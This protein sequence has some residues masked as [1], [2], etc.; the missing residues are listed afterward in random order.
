MSKQL[1]SIM[2]EKA[3]LWFDSAKEKLEEE[4]QQ[5]IQTIKNKP[6]KTMDEF[7]ENLF[8][9]ESDSKFKFC[10]DS[11]ADDFMLI[12]DRLSLLERKTQEK[13]D[14]LFTDFYGVIDSHGTTPFC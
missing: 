5:K 8:D 9:S 6:M 10:R 1:I 3:N 12:K 14:E 11:G 7:F 4:R 2:T 13:L